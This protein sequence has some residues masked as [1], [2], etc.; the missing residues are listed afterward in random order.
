[1]TK[2]YRGHGEGSI[3]Q[4]SSGKWRAQITLDGRRLS[5]TAN[6]RSECQEWIYKTISQIDGGMTFANAKMTF[7]EYMT[8]WLNSRKASLRETT[9]THYEQVTRYYITPFLGHI[10][11]TELKPDQIQ[12]LYNRLL[13]QGVGTYTVIKIHTVLHSALSYAV[14]TG[15][16]RQNPASSTLPPKEP[17]KEMKIYI[18]SQISQMLV[19]AKGNRLEALYHLAVATGMRQMELLGLKW[20]DLDWINQNIKVERQLERPDGKGIRFAPPKTK[21]GKRILALGTKTTEVIRD[22]YEHQHIERLTAGKKWT[23]HG[24]IFTNRLGGPIHPRNLLRDFKDLLK[25]AGLP[26]IRFHDLRH[27][28]ASLM[29]NRGIPLIVASRRLGHARP[30]ITLDVYGHLIPAMQIE[31][32]ELIDELITPVELHPIA[33]DFTPLV[34]P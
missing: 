17:V 19:A 6:K 18:E 26:E 30:S 15:A 20:A 34:K 16:I 1:M 24:L 4:R 2:K 31:A 9:W 27:T 25:D 5:F 8:S 23:E 32:A 10:K 3:H 12:S 29:L 28:S 7:G 22:H 33:P 13:A 14:K 11:I 21:F